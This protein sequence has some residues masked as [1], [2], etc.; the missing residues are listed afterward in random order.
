[1]ISHVFPFLPLHTKQ[2]FSISSTSD[3]TCVP[4]RRGL[5]AYCSVV[6]LILILVVGFRE[7]GCQQMTKSFTNVTN[8]TNVIMDISENAALG[9]SAWATFPKPDMAACLGTRDEREARPH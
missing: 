4:A 5:K 9:T 3:S 1:M 8:I 6:K 2:P 7:T